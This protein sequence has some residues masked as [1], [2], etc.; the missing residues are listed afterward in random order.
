ML[1]IEKISKRGNVLKNF[2]LTAFLGPQNLA[3][4]FHWRCNWT[5]YFYEDFSGKQ[6]A[7]SEEKMALAHLLHRYE[8][9]SMISEEENRALPEV[10][11]KPSR[12]FPMRITRRKKMN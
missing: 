1:T 2:S 4:Q 9:H 3:N 8:F 11:L 7:F 12:G 5:M 6:F 10:T